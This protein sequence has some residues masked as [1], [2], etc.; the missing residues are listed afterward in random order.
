[1]GGACWDLV[2][3]PQGKR[4]LGKGGSVGKDNIEWILRNRDLS[5]LALDS[6]EWRA[7]LMAVIK[8][9]VT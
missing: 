4:T 3:T 2:W 1:M 6:N 5:A 7:L 8:R 9:R